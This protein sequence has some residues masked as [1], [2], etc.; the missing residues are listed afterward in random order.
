M[1]KKVL[2]ADTFGVLRQQEVVFLPGTEIEILRVTTAN[3]GNELIFAKEVTQNGY[4]K[5]VNRGDSGD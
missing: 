1:A 5:T 4:H 3:D 2:I